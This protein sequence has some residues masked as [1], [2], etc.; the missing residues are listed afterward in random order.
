[1]DEYHSKFVG[2]SHKKSDNGPTNEK[3]PLIDSKIP[4]IMNLLLY[5]FYRSGSGPELLFLYCTRYGGV[6]E[7]NLKKINP[8]K[9]LKK[10]L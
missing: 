3:I 6:I 2:K 1:M 9:I 4:C 5:F 8:S 7:V 10:L